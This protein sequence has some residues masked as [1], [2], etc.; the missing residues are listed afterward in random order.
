MQWWSAQ[1]GQ[2]IGEPVK[3]AQALIMIANQEQPP[4]R[5]ITGADAIAMADQMIA[6][7]QDQINAYR[8]LSTSLAYEEAHASM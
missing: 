7:L 4:R 6:E 2:Q 8:E 1:N 5:F 3:L